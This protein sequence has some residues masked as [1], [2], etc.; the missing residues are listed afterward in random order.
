MIAFL[1][2]QD[3]AFNA[4]GPVRKDGSGKAIRSLP[5]IPTGSRAASRP[6]RK[7]FTTR[8]D[9]K[10]TTEGRSV[11]IRPYRGVTINAFLADGAFPGL[12]TRQITTAFSRLR[13]RKRSC[14]QARSP[15]HEK[16]CSPCSLHLHNNKESAMLQHET[17]SSSECGAAAAS[18]ATTLFRDRSHVLSSEA[19]SD[20]RFSRTRHA[21]LAD[22]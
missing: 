15:A 3:G 2:V 7:S 5:R 13:P 18:R 22:E 9:N 6:S 11:G 10:N 14:G 1:F 12:A 4:R 20:L 21:T 19:V 16:Y 8:L 17:A